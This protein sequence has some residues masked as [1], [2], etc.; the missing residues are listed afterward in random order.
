MSKPK[1]MQEMLD[2]LEEALELLEDAVY[3]GCVVSDEHVERALAVREKG[4]A[5]LKKA[6]GEE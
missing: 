6:R 1:V 4:Y 2:A 5:V 3:G